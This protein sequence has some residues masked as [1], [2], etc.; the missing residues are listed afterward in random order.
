MSHSPN[1]TGS[2]VQLTESLFYGIHPGRVSPKRQFDNYVILTAKGDIENETLLP[3]WSKISETFNI[4][5]HPIPS[6]TAPEKDELAALVV[7]ITELEGSVYIACRAGHNRSALIASAVYA[8]RE[9]KS[10]LST[11]RYVRKAWR[12]ERNADK[13]RPQIWKLG[14]LHRKAHRDL[15]RVYIDEK[16]SKKV[17]PSIKTVAT[18]GS[19][20]K[21]SD[22]LFY[23]IHPGLVYP[24]REFANY[25]IL[26]TPG[27]IESLKESKGPLVARELDKRWVVKSKETTLDRPIVDR[28]AP[29][30][31]RDFVILVDEV[32]QLKGSVYI[33]CRGGHGRS[34]LLAAALYA[35]T[36]KTSYEKT[37]S[38]VL[39][40][41]KVQR[42]LSKIRAPI[43]RL[44]SP[45]SARQKEMLRRYIQSL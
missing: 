5:S 6:G 15:L 33:A 4:L 29:P 40:E 2:Y 30:T 42:D 37:L 19:Y 11:I 43:R 21:L 14:T 31:L 16:V 20:V 10:Y 22:T 23:G 27:E 7:Q 8:S 18:P 9:G 41:W 25:V 17:T 35:K 3:S 26:T 1:T 12:A 34:G 44:G 39:R 45:Q 36:N 38:D 32:Y 24:E 13:I 28:R